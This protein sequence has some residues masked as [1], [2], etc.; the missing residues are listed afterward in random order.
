MLIGRLKSVI[1]SMSVFSSYVVSGSLLF[2]SGLRYRVT[3]PRK[4]KLFVAVSI[5]C[6]IPFPYR[7]SVFI[8]CAVVCWGVSRL[9]RARAARAGRRAGFCLAVFF[10]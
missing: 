6:I 2:L 8:V 9:V 4:L 5:V 3:Y 1:P 7:V 10:M